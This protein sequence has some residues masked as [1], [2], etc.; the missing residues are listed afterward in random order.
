MRSFF[1]LI[2]IGT[3]FGILSCNTV[4]QTTEQKTAPTQKA[5]VKKEKKKQK[6]TK[7]D[8]LLRYVTKLTVEQK[9][10]QLLM[11]A[12]QTSSGSW[13][14]TIQDGYD[15]L[16]TYNVGGFILYK[17]NIESAPQVQ[18]LIY[19]LQSVAKIPLLFSIDL[20]GGKVNR[21]NRL[22]WGGFKD[23]PTAQIVGNANS[24]VMAKNLYSLLGAELRMLGITLNMAPV[25]DVLSNPKNYLIGKR[26]F[27]TDVALVERMVTAAVEGFQQSG[28]GA[29]LKHFPGHGSTDKDSHVDRLSSKIGVEAFR[30]SL[31]PFLTGV[32]AGAAAVMVN[33]VQYP[34]VTKEKA[35]SSLSSLIINDILRTR[36]KFHGVVITDSMSMKGIL[37]DF[38][39]QKAVVMAAQAGADIILRPENVGR[40]YQSLLAA[41]KNGTI[42]MEHLNA[43]VVRIIGL[44]KALG[45]MD[46]DNDLQAKF[47]MRPDKLLNKGKKVT[48]LV[49]AIRN[50]A[51]KK[52]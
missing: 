12:L 4:P 8:P 51:K 30:V 19:D 2:I 10:G 42:S 41:V 47:V 21:L 45:I 38:P 29:V 3:I 26:S 18:K 25:A 15:V 9:V 36:M 6:I 34:K 7:L 49:Q 17:G 28:V 13:I 40:A 14:T 39:T 46:I 27:G 32:R 16:S 43:S 11:P 24:T 44:K 31:K 50:A 52:K 48:A 20:E 5:V 23:V 33:H 22:S 35:P 37:K 1:K